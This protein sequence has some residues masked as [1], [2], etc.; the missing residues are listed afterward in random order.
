VSG[1]CGGMC[2]ACYR[3]DPF[4]LSDI[5]GDDDDVSSHKMHSQSQSTKTA[6]ASDATST[7][8]PLSSA[9]N[10]SAGMKKYHYCN[11][12]SSST[13][14]TYSLQITLDVN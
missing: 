13:P 1:P 2:N 3:S 11:S 7:N 12:F 9:S 14:T 6:T 5:L 8:V 10:V 4:D